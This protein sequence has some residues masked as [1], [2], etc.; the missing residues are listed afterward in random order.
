MKDKHYFDFES[1]H[2]TLTH[3]K[4]FGSFRMDKKHAHPQYELYYLLSGK[5]NYFIENR[6]Y[7]IESG[8]LVL[9]NSNTLH[10]T[11]DSSSDFHERILIEFDHHIF[12]T[13]LKNPEE[14]PLLKIF[15]KETSLYHLNTQQSKQLESR[16]FQLIDACKKTKLPVDI[17]LQIHLMECLLLISELTQEI[18]SPIYEH[19]SKLHKTIAEM[20][21]YIH[22]HYKEE[23]SL[24]ILSQNHSLSKVY[25]SRSFKQITGFSYIEYVNTVR[26]REAK[27]LLRETDQSIESIARETGFLS[28]THFGRV[29]RSYNGNSPMQWRK[30]ILY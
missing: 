24:E 25:I 20:I 27:R 4:R 26:I 13:L 1:P 29:F 15:Q 18:P 5:R 23:L 3:Y 21:H 17:A 19:P 16:L 7:P 30:Q 11:I 2:F 8:D 9:V 28:T 10:K 22:N 12:D 6:V 14:L